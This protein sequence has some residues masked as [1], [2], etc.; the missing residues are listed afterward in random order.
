MLSRRQMIRRSAMG[1]AA[2]AASPRLLA[3]LASKPR[4]PICGPK[5]LLKTALGSV[6][7]SSPFL[8]PFVDPLRL[9]PVLR[10][11]LR[12]KTHFYALTMKAGLAKLHRDLPTTVVWGFNGL[13]PGPTIRAVKGEPVVVRQIHH[14]PH[15]A[16]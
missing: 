1:I 7:K 11:A 12:G 14:L 4:D 10:P 16:D 3:Q 2:L 8:T 9:P 13:Y 5:A 15:H 6:A